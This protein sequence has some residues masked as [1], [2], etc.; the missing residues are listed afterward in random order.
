[1]TILMLN[2]W[3]ISQVILFDASPCPMRRRRRRRRRHTNEPAACLVCVCT[4]DNIQSYS[5]ACDGFVFAR[6]RQPVCV[7]CD[8]GSTKNTRRER[9]GDEIKL[10]SLLFKHHD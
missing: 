7:V 2:S 10:S 1:M 9:S 3:Y 5:V 8:L 6:T 4:R